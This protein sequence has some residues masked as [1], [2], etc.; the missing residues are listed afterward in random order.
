MHTIIKIAVVSVL[1]LFTIVGVVS[2]SK[3]EEIIMD[4]S[5]SGV[6]NPSLPSTFQ[7]DENPKPSVSVRMNGKWVPFCNQEKLFEAFYELTKNLFGEALD[8]NMFVLWRSNFSQITFN[9][10]YLDRSASCKI[11]LD[12]T[13]HP[14]LKNV[15]NP[16][17]KFMLD[18]ITHE[19]TFAFFLDFDINDDPIRPPVGQCKPL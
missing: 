13:L 3:A 10:S 18:F 12:R 5:E 17:I 11:I 8:E 15:V 16:E 1:A 4:C 7:W 14:Y 9:E 19:L 6:I 2:I